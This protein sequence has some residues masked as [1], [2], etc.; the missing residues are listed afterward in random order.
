VPLVELDRDDVQVAGPARFVPER[1]LER[2]KSILASKEHVDRQ[3]IADVCEGIGAHDAN[4]VPLAGP[5]YWPKRPSFL[6]DRLIG[7]ATPGSCS[8]A[9]GQL[10]SAAAAPIA[11][12]DRP[13]IDPANNP[14]QT[15]EGICAF[16]VFAHFDVDREKVIT[17]SNGN[18][19]VTG[20]LKVTFTTSTGNTLSANVS[21]PARASTDVDDARGLIR[22]RVDA[23][24]RSVG[25]VR[26]LNGWQEFTCAH[27]VVA[28]QPK[29]NRRQVI[30]TS[31]NRCSSLPKRPC[32]NEPILGIPR[33]PSSSSSR[34]GVANGEMA[35]T[36]LS[37]RGGP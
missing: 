13:T 36:E 20:A 16:T 14:D 30:G 17:F 5:A 27:R 12:A 3:M 4:L 10:G 26:H 19:L 23:R 1:V 9:S 24:D 7:V 28:H 29:R 21:G 18:F 15:F 11:S 8:G 34:K 35:S 2:L 32:S 33:A 25:H 22:T 31:P 37:V 6:A